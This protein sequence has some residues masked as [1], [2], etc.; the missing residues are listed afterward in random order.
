MSGISDVNDQPLGNEADQAFELLKTDGDNEH[1]GSGSLEYLSKDLGSPLRHDHSLHPSHASHDRVWMD[2]IC[3]V[4]EKVPR[5]MV[6]DALVDMNKR[7]RQQLRSCQTWTTSTDPPVSTNTYPSVVPDFPTASAAAEKELLDALSALKGIPEYPQSTSDASWL[8]SLAEF[9][10]RTA[11]SHH[12]VF[13]IQGK[14]GAGKS[15]LMKYAANKTAMDPEYS[16]SKQGCGRSRPDILR[17]RRYDGVEMMNRLFNS[18][19]TR[20]RSYAREEQVRPKPSSGRL[21]LTDKMQM[22]SDLFCEMSPRVWPEHIKFEWTGE[23]LDPCDGV[24]GGGGGMSH[25][26]NC[27]DLYLSASKFAQVEQ[28]LRRPTLSFGNAL[29]AAIAKAVLTFEQVDEFADKVT[30]AHLTAREYLLSAR[31]EHEVWPVEKASHQHN[32]FFW[33]KGRPGAVLAP[34]EDH[35]MM[36]KNFNSRSPLRAAHIFAKA[37]EMFLSLASMHIMSNYAESRGLGLP[38][39]GIWSWGWLDDSDRVSAIANEA[40]CRCSLT[41]FSTNSRNQTGL[42]NPIH[43]CC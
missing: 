39:E 43:S 31:E 19:S 26:T 22:R 3:V 27:N 21:L 17:T 25:T 29:S 5:T 7:Y 23:Y 38:A 9:E 13:W 36:H 12:G 32:G 16:L 2:A 28:R 42:Q 10:E 14:P 4:Q 33:R 15:T 41:G 1:S 20:R 34:A 11:L 18:R 30:M 40:S 8:L 6:R 24:P 35:D 37:G